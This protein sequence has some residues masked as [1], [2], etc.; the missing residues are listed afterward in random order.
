MRRVFSRLGF[1][2]QTPA[3]IVVAVAA[4]WH[5]VLWWRN[6]PINYYASAIV[7]LA[8]IVVAFILLDRLVYFFAQFVLPIHNKKDRR[9]IYNRVRVFERAGRGPAFFVKNGRVIKHEG[10]ADK[11]GPGVIVLDTASAVVLRTDTKIT[12]TAGPGIRFTA[13]EEYVAGSVDLRAQWQFIGPL[14]SEQPFLNPVPTS[15]KN[16]NELQNRRQQTAGWTRDGLEVS[17]SISIR[18]SVKRPPRNRVSE[19]GVMSQYGYDSAS[20]RSAVMGEVIRIHASANQKARLDWNK[21]PE[22]LVVNVWR[23]YVRKF[24]L[25]ELFALKEDGGGPP[26]SGLQF[27]EEMINKRVKQDHVEALDDA[28]GKSGEWLESLEYKQ[29][30]ERGLEITA[31]RIHNVLFDLPLEDK[32]INEW[33]AEWMKIAKREETLLKEKEALIETAA[34]NNASK[35]LAGTASSRFDNPIA[36]ARDMYAT[37]RDLIEPLRDAMLAETRISSEM[38]TE[39]RKM[40]EILKWLLVN[41]VDH[42]PEREERG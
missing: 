38:E 25:E 39:L 9:E 8:D 13:E 41:S 42:A 6:I 35:Y 3:G 11:R 24:K 30:K 22:H 7:F 10:E 34:R 19:S 14:R 37:L 28:G 17:P 29:L 4:G 1:Y 18:F 26:L 16:Y 15:P 2:L 36:P 12:G 23:E 32:R 21:L 31:V 33:S 40:D 27:I 20:V 5:A